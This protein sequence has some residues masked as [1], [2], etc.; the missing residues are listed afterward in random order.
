MIRR[1]LRTG[2]RGAELVEFALV[3]PL[4]LLLVA[5][6]IDFGFLFQQNQV[7][8]NAAREGARVGVL[9]GYADADI[10]ARVTAYLTAA[11]LRG[12]TTAITRT[13]ATVGTQTITLVNVSVTFPHTFA[14][15][16][17]ISAL[18]RGSFAT[19]TLTAV[20]SM[21]VEAPGA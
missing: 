20:C 3:L 14:V 7:I 17:P 6:V 4:L 9:P 10:T 8:T 12:A 18:V 16:G 21:R 2:A 11:G 15:L 1:R 13:T 5:G 19:T